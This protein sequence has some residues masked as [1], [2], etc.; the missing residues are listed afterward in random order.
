VRMLPP[1]PLT[2]P[3]VQISRI[4]FLTGEFAVRIVDDH[5]YWVILR[6][7]HSLIERHAILISSA[8]HVVSLTGLQGS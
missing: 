6:H 4:R 7:R 1:S 5:S 8:I 2:D 3:D